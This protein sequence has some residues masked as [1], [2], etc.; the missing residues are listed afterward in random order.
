VGAKLAA[1]GLMMGFCQE[2]RPV[3]GSQPGGVLGWLDTVLGC[4]PSTPD[5]GGCVPGL[6]LLPALMLEAK[7]PP[8]LL[9]IC[10][11]VASLPL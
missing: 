6:P 1:K 11:C 4:P 3:G 10:D 9:N 2:G 8:P 5:D 7:G